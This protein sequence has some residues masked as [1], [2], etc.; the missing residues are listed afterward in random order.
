MALLPCH[1]RRLAHSRTPL[2]IFFVSRVINLISYHLLPLLVYFA[3][4]VFIELTTR[5]SMHLASVWGIEA[6]RSE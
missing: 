2:S 1:N 6:G 3:I 5:L 4:W